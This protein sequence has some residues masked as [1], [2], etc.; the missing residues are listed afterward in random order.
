MKNILP[1]SIGALVTVLSAATVFGQGYVGFANN[2]L[3]PI[4]DGRTGLPAENQGGILVGLYYTADPNAIPNPGPTPDAFTLAATTEIVT[5][6]VFNNDGNPAF[7]PDVAPGTDVFIQIRAWSNDFA[8]YEIAL[9]QGG[10]SHVAGFSNPLFGMQLADM[11]SPPPNLVLAGGLMGFTVT[12]I[13][14]P[15][16]MVW[17]ILVLVGAGCFRRKAACLVV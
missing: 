6:G 10:M 9:A 12:T 7:I 5:A 2:P 11:N 4:V 16:L 17:G 14:E 15:S 3:T 1:L 8:T 13:P